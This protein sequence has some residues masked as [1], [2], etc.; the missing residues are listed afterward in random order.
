MPASLDALLKTFLRFV[1]DHTAL[2]YG[3]CVA[4]GLAIRWHLVHQDLGRFLNPLAPF[5]A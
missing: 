1:D 4:V 5:F 3:L 2:Y